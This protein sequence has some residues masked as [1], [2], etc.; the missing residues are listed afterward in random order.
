MR[1]FNCCS[2]PGFERAHRA[3]LIIFL[4][5]WSR[6]CM[7]HLS[8]TSFPD[9]V[10]TARWHVWGRESHHAQ[11]PGIFRGHP[12]IPEDDKC[13]TGQQVDVIPKCSVAERTWDM[14]MGPAPALLCPCFMTSSKGFVLSLW[15]LGCSWG[16]WEYTYFPPKVARG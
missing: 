8:G 6:C 16:M 5:C 3:C 1:S 7:R 2:P 13:W 14:D 15:S 4:S 12:Q 11:D 9:Y 10:A